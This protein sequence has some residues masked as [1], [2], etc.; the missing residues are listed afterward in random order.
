MVFNIYILKILKK[1][2]AIKL[3]FKVNCKIYNM[4]RAMRLFN[5]S[6]FIKF[7]IYTPTQYKKHFLNNCNM[8]LYQFKIVKIL[9]IQ[10]LCFAL[11]LV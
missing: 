2:I 4:Y 11:F 9:Q 7:I 3:F 5:L 6:Y 1:K 8:F 10:N